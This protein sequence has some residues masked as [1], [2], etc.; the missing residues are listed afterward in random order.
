MIG[1]FLRAPP[2]AMHTPNPNAP[3]ARFR[4][5]ACVL[6][7][8]RRELLCDDVH[9]PLPARVFTCLLHLIAH[10]DRAVG[11]D[12]LVRAVFGRPDV[13]DAQL[14]QV[15]LRARRALGDNGQAQRVIRTVPSYGFRW[16][17]D[18]VEEVRVARTLATPHG[19]EIAGAWEEP[20]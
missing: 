8:A 2:R 18:V 12:E 11:R 17:A 7:P 5:G 16:A 13:S 3:A 15:V 14:A 6:D 4:F 9:R 1:R 19:W 20:R 10:R